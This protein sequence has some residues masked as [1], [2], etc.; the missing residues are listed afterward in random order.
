MDSQFESGNFPSSLP[1][2]SDRLVQFCHGGPGFVVSLRALMPYF[3]EL[4]E[5]MR[6]VI[7]RA[8]DDIWRRG[9]LTKEPCLC[10]GVAGNALAFDRDDQFHHFLYFMRGER[11]EE[12]RSDASRDNERAGLYTGEAGRVWCWAVADWGLSR[13]CVGYNDV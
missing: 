7:A 8:Q 1:A 11:I 12:L 9:L 4:E 3:P 5:R 10:H 2:G 13:T 6:D